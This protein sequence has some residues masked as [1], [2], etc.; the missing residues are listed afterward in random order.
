MDLR[1]VDLQSVEP[2]AEAVFGGKACGL[3]RLIASGAN[4]PAGFAVAASASPPPQ[5]SEGD[6]SEFRRRT[7]LL[8]SQG[9]LA[10]RSSAVGEDAADRS[11]AGMFETVLGVADSEEALEAAARCIASAHGDRVRT[12]VGAAAP[13]LVG[14][15][16][17]AQVHACSAGVC[18]TID[19][20]G[21]DEALLI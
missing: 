16:V 8:L 4:V 19:P 20:S 10:V 5:W 17:Q 18:F 13:P 7:G 1:I 15:V 6:R 9:L 12:Y 14:V 11:F 2:D 3:A 21:Q